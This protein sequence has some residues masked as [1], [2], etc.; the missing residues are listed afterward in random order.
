MPHY[1]SH[2][3]DVRTEPLVCYRYVLSISGSSGTNGESPYD[4]GPKYVGL[5]RFAALYPW[6]KIIVLN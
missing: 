4:S 6:D 5:H 3:S 2:K 1:T